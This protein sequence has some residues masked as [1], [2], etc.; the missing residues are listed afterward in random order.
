MASPEI[1]STAARLDVPAPGAGKFLRDV[2]TIL[3]IKSR[4]LLTGWYWYLIRPI[5]FPLAM[6][7]FLRTVAPDDPEVVLRVMT[8]AM[9]FGVALMMS[10]MLAQLLIQDRFMGRLKLLITLPVAKGSYAAGILIFAALQTA[11]VVGLLFGFAAVAGVDI[12]LSWVFFPLVAVVLLSMAGP[13]FVI[14]SYAPNPEVGSISAN[15]FGVAL[16]MMS[17][18]FFTMDQAPLLLRWL[19]WVSPMRYAADGIMKALSGRTDVW[20]EFSVLTAFALGTAALGLWK[21]R[22]RER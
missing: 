21:L 3:E 2:W 15:L 1:V 8:G 22:W 7:Y 16:V 17:P 10:N 13:T 19:G 20:I 9:V 12:N 14:A 11:P 18:V 4:F 5:V 6:F